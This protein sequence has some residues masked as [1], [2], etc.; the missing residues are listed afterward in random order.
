LTTY[1]WYVG[2]STVRTIK[3]ADWTFLGIANTGDTTW[4]PTNQW[5]IDQATLSAGQIAWLATQTEFLTGQATAR[6]GNAVVSNPDGFVTNAALLAAVQAAKSSAIAGTWASASPIGAS[7]VATDLQMSQF[8]GN[9]ATTDH[10]AAFAA[11]FAAALALIQGGAAHVRIILDTRQ[12]YTIGAPPAVGAHGEFAQ[13]ALP[14]SDDVSGCIEFVGIPIGN[15]YAYLGG[16]SSGTV[17]ESTVGQVGGPA[18]P[19]YNAAVGIASTFGGPASYCSTRTPTSMITTRNFLRFKLTNVTMRSVSPAIVGFDA[20]WCGGLSGEGLVQFDRDDFA[21]QSPAMWRV[22][23]MSN[24]N[25]SCVARQAIPIIFPFALDWYGSIAFDTLV[26]AGWMSGPLF[27]E[28]AHVKDLVVILCSKFGGPAIGVDSSNQVTHIDRFTDWNNAV[29]ISAIANPTVGASGGTSAVSPTSPA[30]ASGGAGPATPLQIDNWGGQWSQ[31][32]SA[33]GFGGGS[34][35]T[36]RLFDVIDTNDL[37]FLDCPNYW[38][39]D[40][41]GNY[42]TVPALFV[43]G[44]PTGVTMRKRIK[45]KNQLSGPL[46]NPFVPVPASGTIFRNPLGR[47]AI[48]VIVATPGLTLSINGIGYGIGTGVPV[49]ANA[50]MQLTYPA[51]ATVSWE[52]VVF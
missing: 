52:W 41:G 20:G 29:G 17:I 27:G 50:V 22:N 9:P 35:N 26:V 30:V 47:D 19:A 10:S 45:G 33:D 16:T 44:G 11:V 34:H 18:I 15:D 3:A 36:D 8:D 7:R 21:A 37:I 14:Y 25:P 48:L 43:S 49:P 12:K 24:L 38:M 1:T 31:G 46:T 39:T 42:Y 32:G 51:G 4:N 6:P 40:D 28:Y 5:S 2:L 23:G 13:V